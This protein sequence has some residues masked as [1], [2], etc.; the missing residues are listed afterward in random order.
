MCMGRVRKT[1][2]VILP[3]ELVLKGKELGLNLSRICENALKESIKCLKS[4]DYPKKPVDTFIHNPEKIFI[5]DRKVLNIGSG[6]VVRP[7]I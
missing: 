2:I 6:G 4:A 3:P 1:V 5:S 7:S